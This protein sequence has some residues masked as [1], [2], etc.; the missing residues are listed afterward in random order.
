MHKLACCATALLAAAGWSA[1]ALADTT[2]VTWQNQVVVAKQGAHCADDSNCFN[3]YHPQIPSVARANPG[4]L[5]VFETR[6]AL[7]SDLTLNST[8]DDVPAVD[9]NLVHPMTG[10]VHI[11]GAEVGDVLAVTL[12]DIAPDQYGY[13]VIVPG[14]G[15]LR[16]LYTEPYVVNWKLDRQAAT[17]DQMPGVRIPMAAFMGSVGVLPG[18]T[19]VKMWLDARA[20][21]RRGGRRRP[22]AAADRRPARRRLRTRRQ[23]HRPV[24]AHHPAARERRQHGRPADADRH[25]AA[26]A[27]LHRRLRPVRRRRP[28][29]P[30]RRRGLGHRDRDGC[31]GHAADRG[32]EGPR[33]RDHLAALRG[34]ASSSRRSRR[35]ASTPRSASR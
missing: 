1:A 2:D 27:L 17:S 29:R 28:L 16:D 14:F 6:D 11:E 33:Q 25:H 10:P 22:D 18:D 15:F 26:A 4:D 24:P 19:E 30:G 31:R 20:A 32:P 9:L 13:T 7:D 21:A 3:R 8:A 23:P 12:V 34:R 35:S 5:I